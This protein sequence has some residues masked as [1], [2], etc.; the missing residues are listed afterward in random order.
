MNFLYSKFGK[1]NRVHVE[2]H[3]IKLQQSNK[4][5]MG[6]KTKGTIQNLNSNF[7]E[8]HDLGGEKHETTD[9]E[10]KN[11]NN[12][13]RKDDSETKVI[14]LPGQSEKPVSVECGLKP[15]VVSRLDEDEFWTDE[16]EEVDHKERVAAKKSNL[17]GK[18]VVTAQQAFI[19]MYVSMKTWT[20]GYLVSGLCLLGYLLYF[21]LAMLYEQ[22]NGEASIRLFACTLI[23]IFIYS[24]HHVWKGLCR[25][26]RAL[27]GSDQ[28]SPAHREILKCIRF[29]VRWGL[30]GLMLGTI[31]WTLISEGMKNPTNMRALPG[32]VL[33]CLLCLLM[34][35][36]PAK[37]NW[38]TIF[39]G[40][41]LQFLFAL[42]IIKFSAGKDV[43][44]WVQSRFDEFFANSH[45]ASVMM[46]GKTYKD[47]YMVFGGLPLIL[48]S[49]ATLTMLYYV[50]AMV[51]ITKCIGNVLA[52][53]LDTSPVESMGVAASM[54]LEGVTAILCLRP[55]LA[56][57]SK[58]Q[59]FLVITSAFA[60]MGGAY[61]ALLSSMGVPLIFLI[62]AMVVS[63]PATF[64][65]CKLI[66]PET[67]VKKGGVMSSE[68][69]IGFEEKGKYSGLMDAAQTGALSMIPVITNIIVTVIIFV[70]YISWLNH[71]LG[72]LG[73]RVGVQ[74]FSIERLSA[75][76]FYPIALAMG[77]EPND[78]FRVGMLLGYRV[79]V[80]NILSFIKVRAAVRFILTNMLSPQVRS[81]AVVT[82]SLCGF[83]SGM[84]VMIMM[85]IMATLLPRR[86]AWIVRMSLPAL[87]AGNI[88]NCMTGCFA[89]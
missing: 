49:N 18:V 48:V 36:N 69:D 75:Y 85:G 11:S 26:V 7:N 21:I 74:G 1:G 19:K 83:S 40:V 73:E 29:F 51:L 65:V 12:C 47:H 14:L 15:E 84:F 38:H 35:S 31:V 79:A 24:R 43:I 57:M 82:Y 54:F 27:Y 9:M 50:G 45:D 52:F 25:V 53:I 55:Y 41:G 56:K 86:K 58:S 28:L 63:A 59:L 60:S 32:L 17:V 10:G 34:S 44:L 6:S 23:M 13:F 67:K 70:T 33:F 62:P 37:I 22:L 78:C 88:A 76:I 46:F 42:I 72:W 64:A 71:T 77:I 61:L 89:G 87:I 16:E 2:I 20:G 39:W 30:Y 4:S 66:V 81:E 3:T 8:A 5:T 68:V 80:S